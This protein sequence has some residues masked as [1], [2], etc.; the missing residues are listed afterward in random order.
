MVVRQID[1]VKDVEV[2]VVRVVIARRSRPTDAE[3]ADTAET[4][5]VVAATTRSWIPDD[6][7][8]AELAGEVHAFVGTAISMVKF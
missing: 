1:V 4:A 3:A 7:S 2:Q 5:I 8:A 6:R